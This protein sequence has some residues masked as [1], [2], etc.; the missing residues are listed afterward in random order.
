MKRFLSKC[1]LVTLLAAAILFLLDV[2]YKKVTEDRYADLDVFSHLGVEVKNIKVSNIGS[3]HA[4]YGICYDDIDS[5]KCRCFNFALPSQTYDYDLAI[6]HEFGDDLASGGVMIIPVS[7]FSFNN[8]VINDVE[9]KDYKTKYYYLLSP[10]NIPD[11]DLYTDIVTHRIPILSSD[12]DFWK[13][14]PRLSITANA[15][16]ETA[17]PNP[18][19]Y[20][21]KSLDRYNRHFDSSKTELIMPER[22]QN[23]R[24]IISFDK[25]RGITPVLVTTPYTSYY[26]DLVSQNQPKFMT[27]FTKTIT[28]IC[29]DTGVQYYDYSHDQRICKD[30]HNFA[31]GDH[32]NHDGAILFTDMMSKDIPAFKQVVQDSDS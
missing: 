7:Y 21:Q 10:E 28:D 19:E 14:F 30:L 8:E 22:V 6:L 13:I 25:D 26:Y 29:N 4:A 16:G 12:D 11:Y 27:E 15:E 2:R 23:L 20:Q 3:S 9:R 18:A 24:D 5:D 31:D 1:I 17:E 32:L